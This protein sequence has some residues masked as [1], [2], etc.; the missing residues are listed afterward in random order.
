MNNKILCIGEILWDCFPKGRFL[1]GAPFNVACHLHMLGE[2]AAIIS[3]LGKDDFGKEVLKSLREKNIST[4][5]IQ[6]DDKE[7]TG[8][9]NVSLDNI[10][11][12][13]F[14]IVE[15]A[16]WDFIELTDQLIKTASD[17]DLLVFGSLA[18]RNSVSR[19]TIKALRKLVPI[20]VFDVNL[21]PPYDIPEIVED[22][23]AG[24]QIVKLN[25]NEL[26]QI[27]EWFD[28][29]SNLRGAAESISSKFSCSTICIT[30][31]ENGAALWQ[32]GKW[33]EQS[34]YKVH[35]KDTVGSGDAFLASMISSILA[36][37]D[38][39][40]ILTDA[41]ALGAYVASKDGAAP[42]LNFYEIN[43]LILNSRK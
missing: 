35:V 38:D 7:K 9:V 40:K 31:G 17:S 6:L 26:R 20:S 42:P 39:E 41:N 13:V 15:P 34:G 30:R 23:L 18:Q 24:T 11:N 10:G 16:A 14:E 33:T 22:S 27:S 37:S 29:S 1:G 32:N 3:R 43:Q 12:A 4:D 28:F 21:R 5:Y 25:D 2:R 8:I 36:G 19:N